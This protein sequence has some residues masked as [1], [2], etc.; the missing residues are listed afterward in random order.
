MWHPLASGVT[1]WRVSHR[2][3]VHHQPPLSLDLTRFASQMNLVS[4]YSQGEKIEKRSDEHSPGNVKHHV[5]Q[6]WSEQLNSMT[7]MHGCSKTEMWGGG[8]WILFRQRSCVT[9]PCLTLSDLC[10][11]CVLAVTGD[12]CWFCEVLFHFI[13]LPVALSVSLLLSWRMS[14]RGNSALTIWWVFWGGML[15][16]FRLPCCSVTTNMWLY[17]SCPFFP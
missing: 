16:P 12:T 8:C 6:A 5:W 14:M 3:L 15:S 1:D 4:V 9:H 13:P 11:F 2:A 10:L 17:C 7:W